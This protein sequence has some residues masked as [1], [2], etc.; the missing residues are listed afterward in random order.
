MDLESAGGGGLD[1]GRSV[2]VAAGGGIDAIDHLDLAVAC[3]LDTATHTHTTTTTNNDEV[4]GVFT[5]AR[6][7][8]VQHAR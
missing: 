7:C 3:D 1:D 2:N 4:L 8:A 6:A 5:K